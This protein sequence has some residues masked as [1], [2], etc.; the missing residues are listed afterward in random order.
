MPPKKDP[1]VYELSK[2]SRCYNCDSKLAVGDIVKLKGNDEE[3]EVLCKR[4]AGLEDLEKLPSG[5]AVLTRLASKYSSVRFVVMR[6][7][8]LWKCYERQGVLLERPALERARQESATSS[9]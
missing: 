6:W 8:E 2:A 5:N 3:R 4:C 9:H 1:V 7:S